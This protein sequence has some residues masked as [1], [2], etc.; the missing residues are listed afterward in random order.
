MRSEVRSALI[1]LLLLGLLLSGCL[2]GTPA[3]APTE[4]PTAVPTIPTAVPT[5]TPT[6]TPPPGVPTVTPAPSPT[7]GPRVEHVLLIS[8]DGL[9]PDGLAQANTPNIDRLWQNGAYSWKA[10]TIDPSSTLPSHA[11]MLTGRPPEATGITINDWSPGEPFT[12]ISTAAGVI[13]EAGLSTAAFVGK[14]KLEYLFPPGVLDH[15]QVNYPGAKVAEAAA[16]YIVQEKPALVFVHLPDPDGAGHAYGWMSAEYIASIEAVDGAVGTLMNALQQADIAG[17]TA[18]LFTADH[19]GHNKTHGSTRPED[20]T[21]PWVLYG[22][23][24]KVGEV[25][26]EIH[27]YDTAATVVYLLRLEAPT[28]WVGKPVEEVAPWVKP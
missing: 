18:I 24:V 12:T 6:Q 5:V 20:M 28:E 3:V 2:P 21:I 27:T 15:F 11:A 13:H 26:G 4:V 16:E 14:P 19:G 7:P 1:V 8:A 17:T 10:Q 22:P 23:G 9:R 25:M